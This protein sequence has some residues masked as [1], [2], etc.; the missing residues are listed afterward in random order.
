MYDPAG[1]FWKVAYPVAF[2]TSINVETPVGCV[3]EETR[4]LSRGFPVL[5]SMSNV[6]VPVGIGVGVGVGV[7]AGVGVGVGVGAGA[8]LTVICVVP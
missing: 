5:S 1:A 6:I 3:V 8:G 7:G 2:V 4:A